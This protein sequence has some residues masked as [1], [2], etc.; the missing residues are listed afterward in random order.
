MGEDWDAMDMI[1]RPH[2][3][4]LHDC[5]EI[6]FPIND[7]EY[8]LIYLSHILEH[9]PWFQTVDFLIE[10]KR[11][12]KPDGTIEVWVPDLKKLVQAYLD[13]SLVKNDGW[14][15]FNPERNPTKWFNGRLF[16]YGPEEENWHR[17]AFDKEYLS[18]CFMDAGFTPFEIDKPRGADH[19]WINLG[20]GGKVSSIPLI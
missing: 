7:E 6:P 13:P 2:V 8:D 16:T 4:I 15:K 1:K 10:L 18:K 17:A 12:L 14:Y 19:G 3:S 5:R 9:I 20:L 11:I